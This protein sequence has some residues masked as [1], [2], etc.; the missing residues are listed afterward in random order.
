MAIAASRA[1]VVGRSDRAGDEEGLAA[2]I[3]AFRQAV[4]TLVNADH[5]VDLFEYCL[6]IVLFSSLDVHFGLKK[7]PPIRY[8]SVASIGG[9]ASVV[10]STL[11]YAGQNGADEGEPGVSGRRGDHR[12]RRSR[13]PRRRSVRSRPSTP[14]WRSW[15]KRFPR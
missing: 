11:A 4:E 2:A 14:R 13:L 15:R 10:L 9:P 7:P 12:R 1:A 5:Q 6:R 3:P 8:R